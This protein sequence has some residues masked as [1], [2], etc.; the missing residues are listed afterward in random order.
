[1]RKRY[2]NLI[3]VYLVMKLFSVF[4]LSLLALG[5]STTPR[6]G[7]VSDVDYPVKII[8]GSSA[9]LKSIASTPIT[10]VRDVTLSEFEGVSGDIDKF[11]KL[12]VAPQEGLDPNVYAG[13][14]AVTGVSLGLSLD[15]ATGI[16][17]LG[18]LAAD[19]RA[20]N[21]EFSNDFRSTHSLYSPI[22]TEQLFSE[23]QRAVPLAMVKFNNDINNLF[24]INLDE[25]PIIVSLK[26]GEMNGRK[27]TKN[28]I[29]EY[30]GV[31]SKPVEGRRVSSKFHFYVICNPDQ[32][33]NTVCDAK[34]S[35]DVDRKP[36][37]AVSILAKYVIQSLPHG[38]LLYMPP[39]KDL[40]QLPMVYDTS[41]EP[42]ILVQSEK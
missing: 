27:A 33:I 18:R 11:K 17:I 8:A 20:R 6:V 42:M 10:G 26:P 25:N 12:L 34:V 40:Y 5:C 23:I 9:G 3:K 32:N 22:E 41:G 38:S 35:F 21:Y 7:D 30:V 28:F 16:A 4:A 15:Y 1:M 37:P 14:S 31:V 2:Q 13:L 36:H 24:G 39:R 29:Y 19:E